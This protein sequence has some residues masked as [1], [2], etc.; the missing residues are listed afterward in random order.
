[1]PSRLLVFQYRF[2]IPALSRL[3]PLPA[4]AVN[5]VTGTIGKV[6]K[7]HTSYLFDMPAAPAGIAAVTRYLQVGTT[8]AEAIIRRFFLLESRVELEHRWLERGEQSRLPHIIDMTAAERLSVMIRQRGPALLLSGHTT[9]YMALL[10]ALHHLGTRVAFAMI[11]P[12]SAVTG[13][14]TMQ[15]SAIRSADA[16]SRLMP[17]LFTNEG[18]TV[19]KCVQLA[20]KGY[21]VLLL[22][23]VPGYAGKGERV[24]LFGHKFWV[25]SGSARIHGRFPSPSLSVFS[26]A[27]SPLQ[28]YRISVSSP[29]EPSAPLSFQGWADHLERVVRGSPASWFGWF[30]LEGMGN[31][32][33]QSGGACR[34]G[35]CR[36]V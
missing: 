2:L 4:Y 25:P 26:F 31:R 34:A 17:V 19:E 12:R 21:S 6:L 20:E 16:L 11:D 10:W 1:M 5:R 22:L 7:S 28:P 24:T 9:Y 30:T 3:N 14:A 35:L 18:G 33:P 8:A 23:D 15:E 32:L 29:T 36:R 27:P 13:N